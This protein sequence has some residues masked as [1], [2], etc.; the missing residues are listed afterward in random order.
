MSR[1]IVFDLYD[2][3]LKEI[4]L[5]VGKIEL[6]ERDKFLLVNWFVSRNMVIIDIEQNIEFLNTL[7]KGYLNK[8]ALNSCLK[9]SKSN[10][11]KRCIYAATGKD[12][13]KLD[14]IS[15]RYLAEIIEELI[16]EIEGYYE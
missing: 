1:E 16:E 12:I 15:S 9:L 8:E 5:K 6:L 2:V 14:I 13:T 7:M 4:E 11:I 3:I 10:Y